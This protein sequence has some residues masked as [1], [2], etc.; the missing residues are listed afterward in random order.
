MISISW[1]PVDKTSRI[2][3]DLRVSLAPSFTRIDDGAMI[4]DLTTTE[5]RNYTFSYSRNSNYEL[6]IALR[7][8]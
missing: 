1:I 4:F 5:G 7:T 8:K 6:L 2:F 3:E